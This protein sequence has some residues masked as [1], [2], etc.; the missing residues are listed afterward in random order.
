MKFKK[1]EVPFPIGVEYFRSGVPKREVW[2][3][4]FFEIKR[5]GFNIVR[6]ASYWNWMEPSK[7][8]YKLD[9]IDA[10]FDLAKDNGLYVWIDIM[11]AT[12]GACPEWLI[13]EYPDI[14]AVNNLGNNILPDAHPAY[15]QGAMRHCYDHPAWRKYGGKLLDH[16][17]NRYKKHDAMYAWGIWDGIN[18]S[19]AWTSQGNQLPCYCSNTIK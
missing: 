17:V 7:G 11:L 15:S 9:D 6:T 18:L 14:C 3:K 5:R 13:K 19:T 4:D 8:Q 16:V 12:H 2:E 10:F 1:I